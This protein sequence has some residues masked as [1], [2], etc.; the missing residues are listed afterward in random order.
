MAPQDWFP[1]ELCTE[2]L[3]VLWEGV[4][5]LSREF[6]R[7]Q[8]CWRLKEMW[9]GRGHSLDFEPRLT[10]TFLIESEN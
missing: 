7:E 4:I 5:M 6:V 3:E 10:I 1:W 9:R 2:R 8:N